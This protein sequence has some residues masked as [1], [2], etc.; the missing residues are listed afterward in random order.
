[1][2]CSCVGFESELLYDLIS[3]AHYYNCH[4]SASIFYGHDL[5]YCVSCF[6]SSDSFGCISLKNHNKNVILNKRYSPAEYGELRGR[7]VEHMKGDGATR[8]GWGQEYGE[9]FPAAIAPFE[10]NRSMAVDYSPL[11]RDEAIEKGYNWFDGDEKISEATG[12]AASCGLCGKG[13][14]MIPQELKF[15]KKIHVP[16]PKLCWACRLKR[17]IKSRKPNILFENNCKKCGAE[18]LTSINKTE[19]L[20]VYCEKC[21]KGTVY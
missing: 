17:L 19:S 11:E 21:Y 1:M 16:E 4:F 2:D 10:Y 6:N 3:G 13:Y 20:E 14:R 15:Y 12:D 18:I 8:L 9:F 5:E 7:I